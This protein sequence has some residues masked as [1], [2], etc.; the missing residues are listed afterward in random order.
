MVDDNNKIIKT[1]VNREKIEEETSK[2]NEKNFT[3][4]HNAIAHRDK[5]CEKLREN[6]ARDR[7]LK[8]QLNRED[9]NN[10]KVNKFMK[11]LERRTEDR[12]DQEE[13]IITEK[14][15]TKVVKQ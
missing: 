12:G 10:E 11:L 3:K 14:D 2:F 7:I 9:C 4:A 5:T 13:K 8:G 15:W 6:S 1:Y